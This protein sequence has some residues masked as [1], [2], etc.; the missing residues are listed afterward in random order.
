MSTQAKAY[1][2]VAMEGFIADWYAR[3]TAR[4]FRRFSETARAVAERAKPGGRVLEVAPGPGYLAI[5]LA[6]RGYEVVGLDISR[7][8]VRIAT[9]N[10]ASAGVAAKFEHGD[11]AHMPF[12]D[13]SFDFV[14]C[15]AAFKNFTDPVGALDEIHRVLRPGG[16]ASIVDLRKDAPHAAIGEEVARMGLSPLNAALTRWT[17]RLL[18]LPRA[19]TRESIVELARRSRFGGCELGEEGIGFDLRL[20]KG[21]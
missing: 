8:F 15:T 17:F 18:L 16:G 19:Y 13:A 7:S 5:E 20:A 4:D 6:R 12:P 14:V 2:G 3:N 11:V 10:A 9:R 21:A 1:R